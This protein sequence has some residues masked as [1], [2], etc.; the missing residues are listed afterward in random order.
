MDGVLVDS[1]PEY[2]RIEA[3]LCRSLGFER[4][5]EE[6]AAS[7]GRDT[8]S[9]WRDL[10]AA[11][12]LDVDPRLPAEQERKL[13]LEFYRA[14]ALPPIEPS[15][16]L[17]KACSRAGLLTAVATS[18]PEICA[19]TV[20]DRLGLGEYVDACAAGDKV[21]ETKPSPDIF[22]LAAKLLGVSPSECVVV[23]DAKNGVTAAKAA[24]MKAVGFCAGRVPQDLSQADI[25]TE[26]M[27]DISVEDLKRLA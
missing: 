21:K 12:G 22:L 10:F 5:N 4:T 15:V 3:E 27:E 13:M 17:L 6:T 18:S 14:G 11:R 2:K 8:F 9:M 24:G 26:T 19:S 23:E 16:T 25:V 20:I 1:E 7:V